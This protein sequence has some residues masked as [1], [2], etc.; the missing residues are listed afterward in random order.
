MA[1]IIRIARRRAVIVALVGLRAARS[2]R[3]L[4]G[5]DLG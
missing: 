2:Q 5:L 1:T 4:S 3:D